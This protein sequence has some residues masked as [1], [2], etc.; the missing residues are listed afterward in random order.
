MAVIWHIL[1]NIGDA[2]DDINN[3]LWGQTY[4]KYQASWY[5]VNFTKYVVN[6]G[7]YLP[8]SKK[9]FCLKGCAEMTCSTNHI[10]PTG[11]KAV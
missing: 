9:A 7:V 8:T 11:L 2:G 10:L 6:L 1:A 3:S 5:L 4:K